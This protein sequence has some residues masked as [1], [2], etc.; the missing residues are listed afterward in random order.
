MGGLKG[1]ASAVSG[2]LLAAFAS[3]IPAGLRNIGDSLQNFFGDPKKQYKQALDEDSAALA[4]ASSA[5]IG[6]KAT[7]DLT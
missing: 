2:I 1:V 6:Q 3:K 5:N 4:Q 7:I